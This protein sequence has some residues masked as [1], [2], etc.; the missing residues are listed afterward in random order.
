MAQSSNDASGVVW[1]FRRPNQPSRF[2]YNIC[3]TYID[4]KKQV[5]IKIKKK[6]MYLLAMA[7]DASGIVWAHFCHRRP[8]HPSLSIYN[9]NRTHLHIKTSVSTYRRKRK[10]M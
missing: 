9:L 10:N 1:A 5:S 2:I 8:T 7:H 4:N 6:N 3:R